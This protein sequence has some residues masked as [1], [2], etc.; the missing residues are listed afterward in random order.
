[1]T[2]LQAS[3]HKVCHFLATMKFSDLIIIY[4][5]CG[6]PF[7]VYYF[8]N[9]RNFEKFS[10]LKAILLVF[11][12]IPYALGLL[13]RYITE[14]LIAKVPASAFEFDTDKKISLV[15]LQRKFED[16]LPADKA[17]ISR[18]ELRE[19]IER[20]SELTQIKAK[21]HG[22]PATHEYEIF[23]INGNKNVEISALCL[24]RRN[25]RR[26]LFHQKT[27]REDFLKALKLLTK[28]NFDPEKLKELSQKFVEMLNDEMARTAVIEMF[29]SLLQNAEESSVRNLEKELWKA[30][31]Q[32]HTNE[33]QIL[34][35]M[36]TLTVTA[37]AQ[38]KD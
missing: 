3:W 2:D 30:L 19:T 12:W 6:S 27:A 26:L 36:Q 28:A 17:I 14:K 31:E 11:V 10:W 22:P 37:N 25:R 29:S 4:L 23:K 33:N 8:F 32:K 18:F 5:A 16:F 15:K 7:G 9:S 1:M 34:I 13:H 38:E 35:P 21:S 20:Y 24:N